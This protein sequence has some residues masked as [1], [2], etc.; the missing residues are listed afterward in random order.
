MNKNLNWGFVG[1]GWIADVVANDLVRSGLKLDA[2]YSRTAENAQKF[3]NK[4]NVAKN[5]ATYEEF[6]KDP[7][8]DIV[9]ITTLNQ[10]HRDFAVAALNAGKHVLCEKPLGLNYH[11]VAEITN[12]AKTNNR[13]FM[14]AM[15]SRHVPMYDQ[16]K[17][18]IAS[19]A[20]GKVSKIITEFSEAPVRANKPRL[21][22]IAG[23]GGA[24]LDLGIYTV[25]LVTHFLGMPD[26][27]GVHANAT[28]A[29][30]G[31]DESTSISFQYQDGSQALM[32][33]SILTPGPLFFSILGTEGRIDV[34]TL[35]TDSEFKIYNR[36]AEL[37][38]THKPVVYPHSSMT[39]RQYQL[40]EVERCIS[41]GLKESSK[42]TWND[43]LK[44]SEI[45]DQIRK[46]IGVKYPQD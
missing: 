33:A 16:I 46:A 30:T 11:Q 26:L 4:F 37:V 43:S 27:D 45:L 8:I 9:Y 2:I 34:P 44:I 6:L 13:F 25:S 23:G 31:V 35:Y 36:N 20:I 24:L 29:D 41:A 18:I 38:S 40:F 22:D 42:M 10:Q 3:A 1:S 5:Y 39:G 19:G 28:L 12:A 7:E 21:W 14:E 32:S 17:E 15:W